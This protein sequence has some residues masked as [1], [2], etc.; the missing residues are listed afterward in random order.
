MRVV[1]ESAAVF[2]RT[3]LP[4]ILEE[5]AIG[6]PHKARKPGAGGADMQRNASCNPC[7]SGKE[8]Y[9]HGKWR[10]PEESALRLQ[11]Y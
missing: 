2:E 8:N 9:E 3:G 6:F 1:E 10:V 5:M 4:S 11:L 7:C